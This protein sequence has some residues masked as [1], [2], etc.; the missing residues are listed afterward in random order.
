LELGV[1]LELDVWSLELIC[2]SRP[3]RL[4]CFPTNINLSS[5]KCTQRLVIQ[6]TYTD[7]VTRDV[8]TDANLNLQTRKSLVSITPIYLR[9]LMAKL[10]SASHSKAANSQSRSLS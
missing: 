2:R 4:Q 9:S 1:S 8:T 10:N 3:H 5:T 7:G 6:A